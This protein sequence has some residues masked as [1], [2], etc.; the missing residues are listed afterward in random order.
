MFRVQVGLLLVCCLV[1]LPACER[2]K[3]Y[4]IEPEKVRESTER[5]E[6]D[7]DAGV[8]PLGWHGG[9][10]RSDV[11]LVFVADD[12]PDW[13]GLK[14]F[15]NPWPASVGAPTAPIGLA[16]LQALSALVMT[17]QHSAEFKEPVIA[18]RIKVPRGLPD[19]TDDIPKSNPP[20]LGQWR[21]G[22]K[23]FFERRLPLGDDLTSCATCHDPDRGFADSLKRKTPEAG[24]KFNTLSLL[25][26]V[27]NRRQFWDGR[28]ETLEETLVRGVA[29]ER[30]T[31]PDAAKERAVVHHNWGGF[32]RTLKATKVLDAEFNDVF[33]VAHP[34]QDTIARALATY[35]RTLLSGDSVYDRAENLR[36]T[37]KADKLE[38]KHF[39]DILKDDKD[40]EMR[41]LITDDEKTNQT[42]DEVAGKLI[43]GYQLFH[44][45]ARCAQCHTGKLFTDHDFH[46]VGYV[47]P[48]WAPEFGVETGRSASV[49]VGRKETRLIG[50]YRTPT[51]RNL[52]HSDPYFHNGSVYT[53]REVVD[54]FDSKVMPRDE[55]AKSLKHGLRPRALDL[56]GDEM[57][58]LVYFL[59]SLDGTAVDPI[60]IS[61]K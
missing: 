32:A 47:G 57:T 34:T 60:V 39:A 61:V 49:P 55:V 20:T 46:N 26:V 25:N 14:E 7:P 44:G 35:M 10:E 48:D 23:L 45:K 56:T 28:V 8:F 4:R 58:A 29:D 21:L 37:R 54:F 36:K 24:G 2:A 33:G 12:H 1:A 51:L 5:N 50:A 52:V 16:P 22:K 27:Y 17:R 53:L 42:A 19:P 41:K 9:R 13:A 59:R 3:R 6:V 30:A 11:P 40:G 31:K 15:W 38:A 43:A 18:I